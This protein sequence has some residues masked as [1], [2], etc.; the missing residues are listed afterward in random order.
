MRFLSAAHTDVGIKK[1]VNQDAFCLKTASTN[2]RNIVFAVMCDG[3]GGLKMGEIA[4]AFLVNAFSNWFDI[5]LPQNLEKGFQS[6]V[7]GRK[8]ESIAI[9][10]HL[11]RID[12]KNSRMTMTDTGVRAVQEK[13]HV[14]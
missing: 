10:Y 11:I 4:S 6:D 13:A 7:I 3:M 2:T 14:F 8:I 5:I 1:K 9:L 12:Q